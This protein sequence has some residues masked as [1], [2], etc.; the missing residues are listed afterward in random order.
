MYKL[1]AIVPIEFRS[2]FPSSIHISLTANYAFCTEQISSMLDNLQKPIKQVL[3]IKRG[4][5]YQFVILSCQ[6]GAK[7]K[8]LLEQDQLQ[9]RQSL[10][11]FHLIL[12]DGTPYVGS[13][14]PHDETIKE[15]LWHLNFL[16]GNLT[17][18][19]NDFQR[20]ARIFKE[21]NSILR[22]RYLKLKNNLKKNDLIDA[23]F[24]KITSP[25]KQ[26]VSRL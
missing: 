13:G 6:E 22:K 23:F 4:K 5:S 15:G 24:M 21:P 25:G 14:I 17:Y 26:F 1:D 2:L 18:L 20:S 7:A 10:N 12:P 19:M 16:A 8:E 3:L 11:D 9:S